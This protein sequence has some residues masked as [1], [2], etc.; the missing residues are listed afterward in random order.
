SHGLYNGNG[1]WSVNPD[2]LAEVTLTPPQDFSGNIRLQIRV[3]T[4]END[5]DMASLTVPL[6]VNVVGVVDQPGGFSGASGLEDSPISLNLIP[7][8]N[9]IDGSESVVSALVTGLPAGAVL[10]HGTEVSPGVFQ[11]SAAEIGSVTVTPLYN[12]N[13]DFQLTVTATIRESDGHEVEF[14]NP[15]NVK[16]QGV[17]DTPAVHAN[18]IEGAPNSAIAMEFGGSP[19]DMDGSETLYFI[20]EGVP[21]NTYLS[22]GFNNGNG[23]WTVLPGQMDGIT[24]TPPQGYTGELPMTVRAVVRENDGDINSNTAD[25]T[26]SVDSSHG[27]GDGSGG[28]GGGVTIPGA[29]PIDGV[30]GYEDRWLFMDISSSDIPRGASWAI[31]EGVPEGAILSPGEQL[32]DGSWRVG[33]WYVDDLCILPASDSDA[34]INLVLN[35]TNRWGTS[36][37]TSTQDITIQAIA[38]TPD[39]VV[40]EMSGFEDQPFAIALAATLSDTDGSEQLS[41]VISDLPAGATLTAGFLNPFTGVWTITEA[42]FADLQ[43]IPPADFSGDLQFMV[44]AVATEHNGNYATNLQSVSVPIAAVADGATIRANPKAGSEDQPLA[45]N[46]NVSGA[47]ADGSETVTAVVISQLPAGAQLLGAQLLPDGTYS[48]DPNAL[49]GLQVL[50]PPNAHGSFSLLVSATTTEANGSTAESQQTVNFSVAP[51]PDVPEVAAQHV[52]GAEDSPVALAVSGSLTD[53]DGSEVLSVIIGGL[54]DGAVLSA[55]MNNGDGT[56][57]L[58]SSQLSGLTVLPPLN[59]SGF[60]NLTATGVSLDLETYETASF[61]ASFSVEVTGVVD[62]PTIDP[63]DAAGLEDTAIPL[64]VNAQLVDTDGSESLFAV[65]TGV[66]DGSVFS[67]GVYLGEGRWEVAGADLP[68]LTITPPANSGD[69]FTLGL[70]VR[71]EESSGDTAVV[72]D[73]IQVS[74]TAV[75]DA[76]TVSVTDASGSEDSPVALNLSAALSDQDGSENLSL[77]ITGV[78]LSASLSAGTHNGDGSW[79]VTSEQLEGITFTPPANFSG[80]LD[81]TLIHTATESSSGSAV[82]DTV[83]FQVHVGGVADAPTVVANSAAGLEDT[84]VPLD[85]AAAL[86][87]VDGSESLTVTI[88]G[89]PQGASLSAGTALGNGAWLLQPDQLAGLTLQSPADF[90]GSL[91]LSVSATATEVDGHVAVSTTSLDVSVAGVVD[92]ATVSADNV[93][94]NEDQSIALS[95]SAASGDSSGSEA[96]EITLSGVPAGASLSHGV[97]QPDGNWQVSAQDLASVSLTPPLHFSGTLTLGMSAVFT[98]GAH[99]VGYDRTF[100][101]E[102]AGVADAPTLDVADTGGTAGAVVPLPVDSELVDIDGS[103]TLSVVLSGIPAG[104]SVIG[105]EQNDAGDWVAEGA[106]VSGLALQSTSEFSGTIAISVSATSTE[107]NGDTATTTGTLEIEMTPVEPAIAPT[108]QGQ[109]IMLNLETLVEG[110]DGSE[111][112]VVSITGLPDGASLSEGQVGAEDAWELSAQDGNASWDNIQITLPDGY[113]GEFSMGLLATAT[114]ANGQQASSAMALD[115]TIDENGVSAEELFAFGTGQGNSSFQGTPDQSVIYLLD[116]EHGPTSSISDN[117]DWVLLLDEPEVGYTQGENSLDF[118]SDA[119]GSI[120]TADGSQLDFQDVTRVEW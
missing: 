33:K 47:D 39:L 102:V 76:A 27:G 115:V 14:T 110:F 6:D 41:Y 69:S 117:S 21:Q 65:F 43:V 98:D 118:E 11:I 99:S 64:H 87:D 101:V 37:G 79:T 91:S 49:E 120:T 106:A 23:S 72:T 20:I 93:S 67:A 12:S 1:T 105:A 38:D 108:A 97:V 48:V 104:M 63:L 88:S 3:I 68:G 103:E 32:D 112:L 78:P 73:T 83:P 2:D 52:T 109:P 111:D 94:G 34:D 13:E 7:K 56:W 61:S 95:L 114:Q 77:M 46:L 42:D 54:P 71:A 24:L 84:A 17:A 10:S 19:T 29:T 90:S 80:T 40:G 4:T 30:S 113:E 89:V 31:I 26:V 100:N 44:G 51:L 107:S 16:V 22:S 81:M 75:A 92:E 116:A 74:L 55:G 15:L 25:F 9:D 85:I 86:T 18:N 45:L 119:S 58:Q 50:P 59:F 57:T 66:P 82:T 5:G 35:W 62:T 8:L 36:K 53:T 70:E 96:M 28:G 60:L